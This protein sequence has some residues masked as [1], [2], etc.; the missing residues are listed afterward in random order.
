M[1]VVL[2]STYD[3]GRQPFGLASPA[4]WLRDAGCQVTCLDLSRTTLETDTIRRADL[5]A[6]FLPMHTATRLTEPLVSRVR[7]ENPAAHLCAYGLYAPP[8]REWLESIGVQSVLG[9]EFEGDLVALARALAGPADNPWPAAP[10]PSRGANGGTDVPRLA[11]QVPDRSTLPELGRYAAL[12]LPDGRVRTVGYTEAS[13]GCKHLCRH[14]PVVPV[15]NG[16]FRIVSPEVVLADIRQQVAAGARHITF[17]DP[18]FFNGIGHAERIVQAFAREF[19]DVTYDATIKIE[20]LLRHRDALPLLKKTGCVLITSAV[21]SLDDAVL[22]RLEKGHTRADFERALAACRS[23]GLPLA[24]TFIPFTPWTTM[25][26]YRDMLD[27]IDALDLVG[28]VP[29]IQLTLRLLIVAGSRLLELPEI[30][31]RAG[32]FDPRALVY[33]WHHENPAVDALQVRTVE[34]VGELKGHPRDVVFEAVRD[35]VSGVGVR[36]GRRARTPRPR[37]SVPYLNEPWYC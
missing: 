13:R 16:R 8:N 22:A 37:T 27:A 24:P 19:P 34:V 10:A 14:C 18:D 23:A 3:L 26:G 30:R 36:A 15:Y 31:A 25:D 7:V 4:A 35:L 5:V 6:F 32:K 17:G 12:H 2:V 20:H 29:P 9:A 28:H 1:H 21:E 11:F 33:P